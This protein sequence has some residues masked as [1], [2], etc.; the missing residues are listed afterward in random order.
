MFVIREI[1]NK[2]NQLVCFF[3]NRC[4]NNRVPRGLSNAPETF[5]RQQAAPAILK[6]VAC[7]LCK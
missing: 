2:M 5:I 4:K 7:R 6:I 1:P 3:T